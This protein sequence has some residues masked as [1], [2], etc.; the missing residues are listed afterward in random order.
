VNLGLD[1]GLAPVTKT[2]VQLGLDDRAATVPVGVPRRRAVESRSK[3]RR[4]TTRSRTAASARR[5]V[6][7]VPSSTKKTSR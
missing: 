5:C 2:Y 7:C 4:C 3:S 6:P 1:V